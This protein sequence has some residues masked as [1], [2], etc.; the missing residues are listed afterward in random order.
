MA[1]GTLLNLMFGIYL[2]LPKSTLFSNLIVTWACICFSGIGKCRRSLN[3]HWK[4]RMQLNPFVAHAILI[5]R[6][7]PFSHSFWRGIR[8][9]CPLFILPFI[10]I[11]IYFD[12]ISYLVLHRMQLKK[13]PYMQWFPIPWIMFKYLSCFTLT[14]L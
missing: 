1:L 13:L 6:S 9:S 5:C 14:T 2:M 4:V 10:L 12:S 7:V 8:I 3:T 11:F